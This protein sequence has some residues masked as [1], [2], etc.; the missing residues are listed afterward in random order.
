LRVAILYAFLA[1]I[2][3]ISAL[4]SLCI[5]I[6]QLCCQQWLRSCHSGVRMDQ[7]WQLSWIALMYI[8]CWMWHMKTIGGW[9]MITKNKCSPPPP[10]FQLEVSI[11][12]AAWLFIFS[13]DILSRFWVESTHIEGKFNICMEVVTFVWKFWQDQ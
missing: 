5:G 1:C 6:I 9:E 4:C 3:H 10:S 13:L 2:G 8:T 7:C 11:M 12:T